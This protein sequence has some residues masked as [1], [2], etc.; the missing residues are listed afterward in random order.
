MSQSTGEVSSSPSQR[1]VTGGSTGVAAM[2]THTTVSLAGSKLRKKLASSLQEQHSA[3]VSKFAKQQLEKMGWTEGSGLGKH[4]DGMKTHI[5]VKQRAEQAGLGI[6]KKQA[7]ERRKEQEQLWWKDGLADAYAKI[8]T[9]KKKRK[10]EHY[11][12]EELFEATGG[13]RFGMRAGKTRN[14]HKWKRAESDITTASSSIS[15]P[16]T[17][18]Q[19][20]VGSKGKK[21]RKKEKKKEKRTEKKKRSASKE[22]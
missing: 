10:R 13:A 7:E 19:E 4:Q 15:N 20:D 5:K 2:G 12:D 9:K 14:L 6:E 17:S 16:Q 3:P 22:D 18:E 1:G 11:T 8:S 21:K